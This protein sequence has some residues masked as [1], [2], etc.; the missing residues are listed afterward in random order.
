M[1]LKNSLTS[2]TS[3][4][5]QK[6]CLTRQMKFLPTQKLVN[7]AV[8]KNR[9]IDNCRCWSFKNVK[10]MPN[11]FEM[12]CCLGSSCYYAFRMLCGKNLQKLLLTMQWNWLKKPSNKLV[13]NKTVFRFKRLV[14]KSPTPCSI[15]NLSIRS[16]SNL[17]SLLSGKDIIRRFEWLKRNKT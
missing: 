11:I 7:Y 5:Q 14:T 3:T 12:E 2:L 13:A 16:L 1:A 15:M 10:P 17:P 9:W 8:S 6:L 4:D